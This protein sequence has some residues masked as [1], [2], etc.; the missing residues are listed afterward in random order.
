MSHHELTRDQ[1]A[2]QQRSRLSYKDME[3]MKQPTEEPQQRGQTVGEQEQLGP[4]PTHT[5]GPSERQRE[6]S[7]GQVNSRYLLS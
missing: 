3:E 1:L 5:T 2:E 7:E 4:K 6:T